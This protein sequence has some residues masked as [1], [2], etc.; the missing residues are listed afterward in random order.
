MNIVIFGANGPTGRILTEQAVAEGHMVTAVT[1]HPETFPHQNA[2][3]QVVRGDV[4]DLSSVEHAVSGKDAV[5]STLGVP[6][7]RDEIT[8]YSQGVAHIVQAMNKYNVRRLVCVS[9]S[10]TEPHY[11]PQGGFIFERIIQP[12]IIKTIG[13]TLYTDMRRMET[14][15][16]NSKLDWTIVRPSG[17]FETPAVTPYKMAETYIRGR[18]TSR[19]DLANCMLSQL[20]NDQYLRKVVAVGTFAVKPNMLKLIMRE[21]FQKKH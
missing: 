9:S 18:F 21:A 6:F 17:L 12:T 5:L 15:V 20:T 3:L 7:S 4:F 11:D 13:K 14:L 1:R 10:A 16:K 19:A 8:V 2:R